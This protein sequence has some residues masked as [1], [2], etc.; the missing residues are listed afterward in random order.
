MPRKPF[1]G[2]ITSP[3]GP[4]PSPIAGAN[5]FH[6]GVDGIGDGNFA[7][8][9]GVLV[10]YGWEGT[11]GWRAIFRGKTAV[12]LLA[13]NRDATPVVPVGSAQPEGTRL[14]RI[15]SSGLSTGVHC[16]W[17]VRDFAGNRYNPLDWLAGRTTPAGST[18]PSPIGNGE[19][20]VRIVQDKQ[21][22]KYYRLGETTYLELAPKVAEHEALVW[23]GGRAI[24]LNHA[25]V[26]Q[27]LADIDTIKKAIA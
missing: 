15:G 5:P 8:E 10:S 3:Y 26:A 25:T 21:T 12:H 23:M 7:P 13:H 18:S 19:T 27:A 17:E 4:R 9:A 24:A 20:I 1:T 11:Y 2:A 22:K 6:G 14:T 16:H